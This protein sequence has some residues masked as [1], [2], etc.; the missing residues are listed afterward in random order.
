MED[1]LVAP[2]ADW[3]TLIIE[4]R[5]APPLLMNDQFRTWMHGRPL[6]VSSVMDPE[7][8]PARDAVRSWLKSLQAEA[9]MWEAITPRD[10]RAQDAYLDGV[11]RSDLFVLLVGSSY[12]VSDE[13]G[14]SPTHHEGNRAA[15][16]GI[17]RL[18]FKLAGIADHQRDG[19]LNRWI[20]S[21]YSEVSAGEYAN[22]DDL[23]HQLEARLREIA[24][25]QDTYWIKLGQL[26]SPGT[27]QRRTSSGTSIYRIETSVSGGDIRRAVAELGSLGAPRA[28]RLTWVV[29]SQSVRVV[30]VESH[31]VSSSEDQIV[32][33][34]ESA[35]DAERSA[36][37]ALGGVT[38]DG[39]P[40]IDQIPLWVQQAVHGPQDTRRG[41][42]HVLA[43]T[44]PDGPDL[45]AV[46][47]KYQ[48]RGWL[49][50]GL[51]RLYLVEGLAARFGGGFEQLT[52]G[53]AT[54]TSVPVRGVFKLDSYEQERTRV[55]EVV[56]LPRTHRS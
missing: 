54:A 2:Y 46:L 16:R 12:G 9:V 10:Q 30:N 1:T 33:T 23:V 48:A 42:D 7:M 44:A 6:F 36:F 31:S 3:D 11:D 19:Q 27:V 5:I 41:Q 28:S 40:P 35:P 13:S 17:P 38:I 43:M 50:E 45:A 18:L 15:E 14:F 29:T 20:R 26:V 4:R 24:S 52:V 37:V 21:L 47:A 55:D 51:V 34:C 53:P 32:I 25:T 22:V 56:P 8:S 49:A 39:V